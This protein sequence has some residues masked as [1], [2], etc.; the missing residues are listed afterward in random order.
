M[1]LILAVLGV[2]WLVVF[3]R[4]GAAIG[5]LLAWDATAIAY[6]VTG[7]LAMRRG[8]PARHPENLR[9]LVGPRWY[10]SFSHW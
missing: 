5:L 1:E 9:E 3:L 7:R 4:T 2:A 8:L 6:M 10:T